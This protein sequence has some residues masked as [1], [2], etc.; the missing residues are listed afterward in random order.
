MKILM[1]GCE[2]TKFLLPT[3]SYLADKYL[4]GFDKYY[5]NFGSYDG[6]IFG[7]YDS[8]DHVTSEMRY[9]SV[10]IKRYMESLSDEIVIFGLDDYLVNKPINIRLYNKLLQEVKKG[11]PYAR[12]CVTPDSKETTPIDEE[13]FIIHIN[14]PYS[15]SAQF[16]IWNRNCLVK[17]LQIPQSAW[18]F[19][20]YSKQEGGV[21][22][23]E[24][25][26]SYCDWSAIS[27]NYLGKVNV[28]DVSVEDINYLVKNN[29]LERKDLIN[30]S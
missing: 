26:I 30:L 7:K 17:H 18:D 9:W 5:F 10:P 21:G 6:K 8:L 14:S 13:M 23:R 20:I 28:K 16:T 12:L 25:T 2:K 1:F 22:T 19:E 4:P 15:I 24:P 3:S 27:N 29:Y 11:R